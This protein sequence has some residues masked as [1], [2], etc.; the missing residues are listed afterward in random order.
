[1]SA[2]IFMD[3]YGLLEYGTGSHNLYG[4]AATVLQWLLRKQKNKFWQTYLE[5]GGGGVKHTG[6][7]RLVAAALISSVSIP[8]R[9]FSRGP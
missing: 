6:L 5:K 1:M 2:C 4:F 8:R 9:W 3:A 7:Q